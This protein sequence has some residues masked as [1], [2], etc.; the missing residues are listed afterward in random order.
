MYSRNSQYWFKGIWLFA[1]QLI[2][3]ASIPIMIYFAQL[4]NYTVSFLVFF[5]TG[6]L[7]MSMTYHRYWSHKSW[8]AP[9]S[10]YNVATILGCLG[11]TGSPLAWCAIHRKHHMVTDKPQDP[12]SPHHHSFLQV[13]FLSMFKKPKLHFVKDL[14]RIPIMQLTHRHYFLI[15]ALYFLLLLIFVEP[16]AVVYAYLFPAALLW[17]G[18]SLINTLGHKYGYRNFETKE[19]SR[20]NI[21]LGFL[22]WGEGWHNNHHRYPSRAHFSV[23]KFEID[24]S[25]YLI[26]F[27]E[28]AAKI[29]IKDKTTKNLSFPFD[30]KAAS[31]E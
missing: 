14:V 18:G 26:H 11:L 24:V 1:F 19:K 31:H 25:G 9:K 5:L 8:N 7:G 12:H 20:N 29:S 15:N 21:I 30:K 3:H 27:L 16:F 4:W 2:A 22:M 28:W 10:F 23:K 13:Q 6:C 17:N